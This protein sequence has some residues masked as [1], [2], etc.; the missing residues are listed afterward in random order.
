MARID[1]HLHVWALDDDRYSMPPGRVPDVPGD[2]DRLLPLMDEA[3]IDGAL[4]VQPIFHG[5]DHSYVTDA[6][7]VHP[8][9]FKGMALINPQRVDAVEQ[10]ER[11]V[12]EQGYCGVR[13]NP[14]LWV[15]GVI[16]H[17]NLT[18]AERTEH[19]KVCPDCQL[20]HLNDEAGKAVY[21]KAGEL[22]VPV[23]FM[24]SPAYF[25]QIDD[26]LI[27][28]P[29]TPAIIDHFGGCKTANG[30]GGSN[31]D[32]D[33]LLALARHPQLRIKVSGFVG[34]SSE[35]MPHRDTW[36]MVHDLIKAFGAERLMWGTDFPWIQSHGGY[37]EGTRII[38]QIPDI[39]DR[40]RDRLLGGAATSL[41]GD[42][43]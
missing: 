40:D 24:V 41:F 9:R 29:G 23:G 5:F 20:Q 17:L 18:P 16:E 25:G 22:G 35:T 4:I 13:F 3:G 32:W 39:S 36:P 31:P 10:L 27:E 15:Y 37:V 28:F 21:Q 33:A 34:P 38:D 2:V 12:S 42:W 43:S 6:I 7:A 14:A 11:L 8:D 30:A 1:S 26:L 19:F